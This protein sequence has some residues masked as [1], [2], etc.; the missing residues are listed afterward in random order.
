MIIHLKDMIFFGYHGVYPEERKLGQRFVV[1]I[2]LKTNFLLDSKILH[3]EDTVDYTKV[4]DEIKHIMEKEQFVLLENCANRIINA[5]L[6]KFLLILEITVKI[7]KPGVPING[8]LSS[9]AIE[10]TRER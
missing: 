1:N 4:Y 2:A 7:E 10:M 5:L 3:I 8:S 9:V 6:D